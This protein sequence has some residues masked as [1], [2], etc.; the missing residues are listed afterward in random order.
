MQLP[1]PKCVRILERGRGRRASRRVVVLLPGERL[2]A[3]VFGQEELRL[4]DA[5]KL[6][7][8]L[9]YWRDK[10]TLDYSVYDNTAP[11]DPR[12][13]QPASSA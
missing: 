10:R 5:R 13:P 2:D 6:I 1:A 7:G 8:G 3:A 12:F 4:T 9:R 11:Q